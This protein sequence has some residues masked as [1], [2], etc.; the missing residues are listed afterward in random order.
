MAGGKASKNYIKLTNQIPDLEE[1]IKQG[2]INV[3]PL[4]KG[5]KKPY[6]PSWN[7][8]VYSLT[9]SFTYT[10]SYGKKFTQSGLQY[11]T[12]NYGILIGYGNSTN[13]Y[14]IG[15]IDIDGYKTN[16]DNPDLK[17][18]KQTQ[19]LIY[20]ALKD[21]PNSLQ[22]KTQSG[23]YHI[24]Y[25]TKKVNPSTKETSNSLYYPQD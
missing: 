16:P 7:N 23:G 13:G 17:L 24:Y 10:N 4:P 22:V 3:I 8:R 2:K 12:G 21:L 20:E 19:K 15:C 25:W 14:S 5:K 11:H 6:I 18:K 1:H 9:E